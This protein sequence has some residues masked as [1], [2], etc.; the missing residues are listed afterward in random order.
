M[1][2]PVVKAISTYKTYLMLGTTSG[3]STT[4]AKLVDIVSYPDLR[5]EPETIDVTTLSDAM[6]QYIPGIMDP[7]GNLSFDMNYTPANYKAVNDLDDGAVHKFAVWFG[8]STSGGVDTPDGSYGKFEFDAYCKARVTGGG[9][10][11]KVS[12]AAVLTPNSDIKY[13]EPNT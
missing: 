13:V 9:V 7:G 12:M 4:W 5:P 6:R 1:A 11:E 8:A 3:S 2:D 10:N